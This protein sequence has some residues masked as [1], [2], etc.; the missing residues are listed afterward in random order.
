MTFEPGFDRLEPCIMSCVF[1]E[2]IFG[3][4]DELSGL[5]TVKDLDDVMDSPNETT[6]LIFG[7]LG[8][9]TELD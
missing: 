4:G 8:E 9:A 5:M 3:G 6:E 1:G 7:K 2:S